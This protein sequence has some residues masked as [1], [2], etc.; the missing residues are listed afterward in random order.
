MNFDKIKTDK[1][2]QK[3]MAPQT[4]EDI[5]S[6]EK[7]VSD[8]RHESPLFSFGEAILLNKYQKKDIMAH[9]G[10][11][12]A[13][14]AIDLVESIL[15]IKYNDYVENELD[16]N[17][18]SVFFRDE[19]RNRLATFEDYKQNIRDRSAKKFPNDPKQASEYADKWIEEMTK[20]MSKYTVQQ[21]IQVCH[22]YNH[23]VH[24][25]RLS[26]AGYT[27]IMLQFMGTLETYNLGLYVCGK[28]CK[29][30]PPEEAITPMMCLDAFIE[31][32]GGF[33]QMYYKY[34]RMVMSHMTPQ[35]AMEYTEN[36]IKDYHFTYETFK[37]VIDTMWATVVKAIDVNYAGI[38]MKRTPELASLV[39]PQVIDIIT[40][41]EC[42]TT[43]DFLKIYGYDYEAE[44]TFMPKAQA[45]HEYA[46]YQK[47]IADGHDLMQG[48]VRRVLPDAKLDP[49]AVEEGF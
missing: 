41:Y 25:S 1:L 10:G 26:L 11:Y 7:Q 39:T 37:S 33:K 30:D 19:N 31:L 18:K 32:A 40:A 38:C 46:K 44:D 47:T 29:M 42:I 35:E 4:A 20:D 21:R 43:F 15:T 6:Y 24:M 13:S 23:N 17:I 14:R 27:D 9:W 8:T 49:V 22:E 36:E 12:L 34:N 28:T 16:R 45:E 2:I 5:F 3:E 48:F